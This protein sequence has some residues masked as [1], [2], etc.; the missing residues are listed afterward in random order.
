MFSP[1]LCSRDATL[2]FNL[3]NSY[4]QMFNIITF[5]LIYTLRSPHSPVTETLK[6]PQV[7]HLTGFTFVELHIQ[8]LPFLCLSLWVGWA[9][10]GSSVTWIQPKWVTLSPH[11]PPP[12]QPV[13]HPVPPVQAGGSASPVGPS[14][15]CSALI[16]DSAWLPVLLVP[17]N[18]TTHSVAV[19]S[20]GFNVMF[21]LGVIMVRMIFWLRF[22]H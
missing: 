18:M 22:N 1:Q 21:S 12:L 19:S 17:T 15:P 6:S 9:M 14:C 4:L 7:T 2:T 20:A 10:T 11:P 16:V 5:I 8:I 13:S 3:I